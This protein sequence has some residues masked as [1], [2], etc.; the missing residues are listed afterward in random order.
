MKLTKRTTTE[1][2]PK[3]DVSLEIVV[4]L[5]LFLAA[6]AFSL[7]LGQKH[8]DTETEVGFRISYWI[9]GV[10]G[11][12]TI[13]DAGIIY[14]DNKKNSLWS[15]IALIVLSIAEFVVC[16]VAG[17]EY[18]IKY[19]VI[20][21]DSAFRY[22]ARALISLVAALNIVLRCCKFFPNITSKLNKNGVICTLSVATSASLLSMGYAALD[23]FI[24][25]SGLDAID[26]SLFIVALII[27]IAALV[28]SCASTFLFEEDIK[29]YIQIAATITTVIVSV[30]AI[31]AFI[32]IRE[33]GPGEFKADYWA[34]VCGGASIV[35]SLLAFVIATLSISKKKN[36]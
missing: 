11:M 26:S 21:P 3:I 30:I 28:A 14:I 33:F 12:L 22:V 17:H 7:C 32:A 19:P 34:L 6:F 31:V 10:V 1:T 8:Y 9:P 24:K 5:L 35:A 2:K 13:V 4:S 27:S 25:D 29:S 15:K 23:M 20:G 36:R 18:F 16:I